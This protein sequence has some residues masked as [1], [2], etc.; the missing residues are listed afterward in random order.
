MVKKKKDKQRKPA[1]PT[2]DEFLCYVPRR[3]EFEWSTNEGGL[4]QIKVPKFKSNFGKSFCKIIKKDDKFTANLDKIG[5]LI[6]K[7]C[8]GK[9]SVKDILE[10]LKKEFPK[11]E[12]IDQRLFLFLLQMRSLNYLS[13]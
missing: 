2:V 12:N 8:D 13:L 1:L 7:N 10:I 5:S 3:A 6:W 4:V 9:N 11:E